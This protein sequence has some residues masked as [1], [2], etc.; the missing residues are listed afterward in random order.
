MRAA[1][2]RQ[3]DVVGRRVAQVAAQQHQAER[4]GE[5]GEHRG[6]QNLRLALQ[7]RVVQ[8]IDELVRR[9]AGMA[10]EQGE[11]VF[12]EVEPPIERHDDG[13]GGGGRLV[14]EIDHLLRRA[15][16]QALAVEAGD[17]GAGDVL[18][19]AHQLGVA[20]V[21]AFEDE[22]DGRHA[23]QLGLGDAAIPDLAALRL[24]REIAR[25]PAQQD[26]GHV[27]HEAAAQLRQAV[28]QADAGQHV[29]ARDAQERFGL[30][31]HLVMAA[32]QPD[33]A[34]DAR[35]GQHPADQHQAARRAADALVDLDEHPVAQFGQRVGAAVA[36]PPGDGDELRLGRVDAQLAEQRAQR[37]QQLV[38]AHHGRALGRMQDPAGALGVD[39]ERDQLAHRPARTFEEDHHAAADALEVVAVIGGHQHRAGDVALLEIGDGGGAGVEC[40]VVGADPAAEH[41]AVPGRVEA[42]EIDPAIARDGAR[43]H[44]GT[45]RQQHRLGLRLGR[46]RRRGRRLDL[47]AVPQQPGEGVAADPGVQCCG[48]AGAGA[49][50][51]RQIDVGRRVAQL[52]H[53]GFQEMLVAGADAAGAD[54]AHRVRVAVAVEAFGERA[55][56]A[57]PCRL[58]GREVVVQCAEPLAGADRLGRLGMHRGIPLRIEAQR[59]GGVLPGAPQAVEIMR[60]G[61]AGGEVPRLV[62]AE[63]RLVVPRVEQQVGNAAFSRAGLEVMVV[64]VEA[65]VLEQHLVGQVGRALRIDVVVIE[66]VRGAAE[67]SDGAVL[68]V[69]RAVIAGGDGGRHV[70][71]GGDVPG[72]VEE[73]VRRVAEGAAFGDVM[74]A[75]RRVVAAAMGGRVGDAVPVG[76]ET[77]PGGL[78][79]AARAENLVQVVDDHAAGLAFGACGAREAGCRASVAALW[80]GATRG[81]GRDGLLRVMTGRSRPGGRAASRARCGPCRPASA[82]A[83]SRSRARSARR[84]PPAPAGRRGGGGRGAPAR[85]GR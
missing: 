63:L 75:E 71:V 83:P 5:A 49:D 4:H 24:D 2:Q 79:V 30:Q 15:L 20:Q 37:R 17:G 36:A 34:D 26:G 85:A 61:A 27:Q 58:G 78:P 82:A 60:E 14:A 57:Q 12:Q 56:R 42:Q 55:D 46:R 23:L 66:P 52:E 59:G 76:I 81:S 9:H 51:A 33:R 80:R 54:G 62:G 50:I 39:V 10:A 31:Q 1:G 13:D 43:Q 35:P 7:R 3:A 77:A 32:M 64:A 65:A 70:R 44:L 38:V 67:V 48:E 18:E 22:A 41:P 72:F 29:R 53:A 11:L 74:R 84:R 68:L 6:R 45:R 8:H 40:R 21:E 69:A 25:L 28:L 16:A 47:G 19:A 73:H